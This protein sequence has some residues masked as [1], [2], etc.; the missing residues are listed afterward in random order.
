MRQRNLCYR[1]TVLVVTCTRKS[2]RRA[3]VLAQEN[4]SKLILL[5][6]DEELRT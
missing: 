6:L 5:N 1:E 4:G 2:I 3:L